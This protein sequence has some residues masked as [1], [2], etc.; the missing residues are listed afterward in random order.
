MSNLDLTFALH[1]ANTCSLSYPA[2][3]INAVFILGSR[4]EPV[5]IKYPSY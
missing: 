4:S 2:L 5:K 1:C 3:D